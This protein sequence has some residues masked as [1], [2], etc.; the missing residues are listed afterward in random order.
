MLFRI[1]FI[2]FGFDELIFA[3]AGYLSDDLRSLWERALWPLVCFVNANGFSSY[4]FVWIYRSCSIDL[5]GFSSNKTGLRV[6]AFNLWLGKAPSTPTVYIL[7]LFSCWDVLC[8]SI[9]KRSASDISFIGIR[10]TFGEAG[11]LDSLINEELSRI[12]FALL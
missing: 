8:S 5:K 1:K 11:S 12:L 10:G 4:L 2:S 9:E 6:W 7:L 3:A